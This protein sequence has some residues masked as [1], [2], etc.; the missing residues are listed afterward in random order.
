MKQY[1]SYIIYGI[2]LSNKT[3]ELI[4]N[5]KINDPNDNLINFNN[6]IKQQFNCEILELTVPVTHLIEIKQYFLQICIDQSDLSIIKMENIKNITIDKFSKL[7][8][9]LNIEI[10]VPYLISVPIVRLLPN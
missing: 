5:A 10:T 4:K 6:K 7:L 9:I 8:E 2:H 3:V 1:D